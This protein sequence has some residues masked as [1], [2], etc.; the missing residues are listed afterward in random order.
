VEEWRVQNA[1]LYLRIDVMRLVHRRHQLL[2]L[3]PLLVI[4]AVAVY[5]ALWSVPTGI[6]GAAVRHRPM[7][8]LSFTAEQPADQHAALMAT[9]I[10]R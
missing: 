2:G 1:K 9:S 4:G 10:R 8:A 6:E 3:S 7:A 5:A